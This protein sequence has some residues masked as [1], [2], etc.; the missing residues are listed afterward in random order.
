MTKLSIMRLSLAALAFAALAPAQETKEAPRPLAQ[1]QKA[2]PF[3]QRVY[4]VKHTDPRTLYNVAFGGPTQVRFDPA[5]KAIAVAGPLDQVEQTLA[6]F[7]ELDVPPSTGDV[8]DKN[9]ELTVWIISASAGE[10]AAGTVP[11]AI[12]PI[13]GPL[14]A[15]LGYNAFTL[16]DAPLILGKMGQDSQ[17]IGNAGL[18]LDKA[19][20]RVLSEYSCRLRLGQGSRSAKGET[21]LQVRDLRFNLKAPYCQDSE[22]KT[23]AWHTIDLATQFDLREGQKVVVGKSKMADS[24]RGLILIVSAKVVD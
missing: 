10:A 9:V 11:A 14:R 22:C 5:L 23:T 4:R 8:S 19:P 15:A 21:I 6:I 18:V 7:K 1:T 20:A 16:L 12:A 24:D 3:V 17:V 13:L 2:D